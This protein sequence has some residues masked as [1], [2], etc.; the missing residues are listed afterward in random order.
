MAS[1]RLPLLLLLCGLSQEA[2]GTSASVGSTTDSS[3][4]APTWESV[5][6]EGER[7]G[8]G[9]L[10][11]AVQNA[12]SVPPELAR[13][14]LDGVAHGLAPVSDV[15][16]FAAVVNGRV[17]HE[18]RRAL[19]RGA[20]RAEVQEHPEQPG[21]AMARVH[22]LRAQGELS[23]NEVADGVRVG[24]QR[25]VGYDLELAFEVAAR[26]PAELQP[27]IF[28]ELGWRLGDELPLRVGSLEAPLARILP[29]VPEAWHCTFVHGVLR[30]VTM[31]TP[32]RPLDGLVGSA[33]EACR[34]A[35]AR[36]VGWAAW[37]LEF[38]DPTKRDS[39]IRSLLK[40]PELAVLAQ[41]SVVGEGRAGAAPGMPGGPRRLIWE[42]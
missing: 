9:P 16:A 1:P 29:K 34:V 5:F 26:W 23:D 4:E 37:E 6:V 42:P 30:G 33:P 8:A 24:L 11:G 12:A 39:L 14:Y 10:E 32:G 18:A 17:P 41:E 19:W 2:C 28:E 27:A 21:Q 22:V 36:G 25:A 13:V 35:A 15:T 31:R 38:E 7:L 40:D 20:I 3:P